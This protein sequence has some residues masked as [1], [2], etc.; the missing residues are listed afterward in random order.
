M[1]VAS[2]P[3]RS[4]VRM[5]FAPAF[6]PPAIR[7]YISCPASRAG[8]W[9]DRERRARGRTRSQPRVLLVGPLNLRLL[10]LGYDA[11][12]NGIV[13]R[14]DCRRRRADR[15][16][17][18]RRV[19]LRARRVEDPDDRA[20]DPE[21][22]PR[23]LPDYEIGVV[24]V[25]ADHDRVGILDPSLSQYGRVHAV[26]DDEPAGPIFPEAVEGGLLLVDRR[27]VPTF[28]GETLRDRRAHPAAADDDQL[29]RLSVALR[30]TVGD[31]AV[32]L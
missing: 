25:R 17:A 30:S 27:H 11:G 32:A 12:A 5:T 21:S 1:M 10:A 22:L 7:T 2:W 28:G 15:A 18:Q 3:L 6:P 24:T 9:T 29:H 26:A 19:E 16:H 13:Q 20:V 31:A 23:H 14:V 8:G 4:S